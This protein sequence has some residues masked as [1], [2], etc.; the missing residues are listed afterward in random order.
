MLNRRSMLK[1]SAAVLASMSG[2]IPLFAQTGQMKMV[3]GF[4]AGGIADVLARLFAEEIKKQTGQLVVVENRPGGSGM[5]AAGQVSRAPVD[6]NT[7]IMVSGGYT[8]IPALQTIDFDAKTALTAINLIAS[9]PNLL[10]VKADA[11]YG[12]VKS[13]VS[14]AK[15]NPGKL[16]YGSSGIGAT[17]HFMALQLEK[18]AGIKLVHV[19]FKSSA[20]SVQAV[21][22]GH[23]PMSF[24]AVN[25][26]LPLI[27]AGQVR[28]LAIAAP[29]R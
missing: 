15:A 14:D 19:P 26:A 10:V 4:T 3:V 21:L 13:L 6:G 23:V 1:G 24:S 17:V 29:E 9:A 8:I 22:G 7:L 20:E 11:K 25:S 2:A 27:Q 5:T 28:A 18:E 16:A 12:D